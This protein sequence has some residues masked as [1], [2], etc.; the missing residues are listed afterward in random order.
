[1]DLSI[2]MLVLAALGL[3]FVLYLALVLRGAADEFSAPRRTSPRTEP[4]GRKSRQP[5]VTEAV[6][7][8]RAEIQIRPPVGAV[9]AGTESRGRGLGSADSGETLGLLRVLEGHSDIQRQAA[10][11]A[12]A[13]PF[14][15]TCEPE[16]ADALARLVGSEDATTSV[17]AEAWIALRAVMGEE[18]SW[19]DEVSVRHSFPVGLDEDWLAQLLG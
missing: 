19:E 6:L 5:R 11:Q 7:P 8:D 13:L 10:C 18:L 3:G 12:L 14:A 17:R 16:V 9:A 4:P 2:P 1:M 15:G